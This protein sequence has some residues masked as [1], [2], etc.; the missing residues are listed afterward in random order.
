MKKDVLEYK[1][2]HTK[3]EFDAEGLVLR[4]KIEGINDFVDFECENL[5]DVEKE[6]HAAV[7]SY[8]E[9]CE[10]VGKQPEKEY[11]GTF[12]V[13]ISPELH[14]RLAIEALK[15]GD[16]LNASVEKA[17]IAYVSNVVPVMENSRNLTTK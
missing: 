16:T 3:I 1:G 9:F 8:L 13:R 4:G 11:K 5:C 6:F 2:Y 17:I 15:N 7:D 10:E 12:N 14:K